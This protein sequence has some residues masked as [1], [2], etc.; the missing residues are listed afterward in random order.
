MYTGQSLY[1]FPD[2]SAATSELSANFTIGTT[3]DC[4]SLIDNLSDWWIAGAPFV[5][6]AGAR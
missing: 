5:D 1:V 2:L 3:E 4:L 6:F